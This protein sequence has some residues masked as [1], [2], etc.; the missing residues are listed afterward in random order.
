MQISSNFYD[1]ESLSCTEFAK[2][3]PIY[4]S[5]NIQSLQ[6]KFEQLRTELNDFESKNISIDIIALQEIWDVNYP[7]LFDIP[8]YKPLICKMRRGMRGG[9]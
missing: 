9:V 2:K 3:K 8:G 6:S 1:I 4:L 7:E 5:I